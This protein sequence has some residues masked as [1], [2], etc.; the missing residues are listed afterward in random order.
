MV[1]ITLA[2][3]APSIDPARDSTHQW[4]RLFFDGEPL[5]TGK[6]LTRPLDTL[7]YQVSASRWNQ[8]VGAGE[9]SS[10]HL[11]ML[12]SD[13]SAAVADNPAGHAG[14]NPLGV[15]VREAR[16]RLVPAVAVPAITPHGFSQD[17]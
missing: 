9:K 12:L 4:V 11:L 15:G 5:G 14:R 7:T 2:D 8:Q 17:H 16:F 13:A 10:R 1:E 3:L 6:E